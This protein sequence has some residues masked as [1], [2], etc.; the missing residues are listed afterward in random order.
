MNRRTCKRNGQRAIPALRRGTTDARRGEERQATRAAF[1][2]RCAR[3]VWRCGVRALPAVY[4]PAKG[5]R[6]AAE[7]AGVLRAATQSSL[8]PA[9]SL[10]LNARASPVL[11]AGNSWPGVRFT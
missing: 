10:L 3:V 7:R 6:P 4:G 11:L 1:L 5:R 2:A 9:E 8:F